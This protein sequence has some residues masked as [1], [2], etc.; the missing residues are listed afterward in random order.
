MEKLRI[1]TVSD[2]NRIK[3]V[4]PSWK[5]V[6]LVVQIALE[7]SIRREST[8]VRNGAETGFRRKRNEISNGYDSV[9][10]ADNP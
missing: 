4:P 3:Q 7:A 10:R 2:I 1:L 5:P 8:Q 9:G 6:E